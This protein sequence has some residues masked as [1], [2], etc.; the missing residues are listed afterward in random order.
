MLAEKI[1]SADKKVIP[2]EGLYHEIFNEPEREQ[3]LDDMCAWLKA[4]VGTEAS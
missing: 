2:Y 4:H 1:S 3:V